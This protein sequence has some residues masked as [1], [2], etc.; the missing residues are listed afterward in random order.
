MSSEYIFTLAFSGAVCFIV[1][2]YF[3]T[4]SKYK[5][6]KVVGFINIIIGVISIFSMVYHI[7][8]ALTNANIISK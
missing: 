4:F 6:N 5:T 8:Q 1:G 3:T 7:I 2:I